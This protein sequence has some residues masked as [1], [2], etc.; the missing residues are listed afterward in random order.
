MNPIDL[1]QQIT[2][3]VS[4]LVVDLKKQSASINDSMNRIKGNDMFTAAQNIK[5]LHDMCLCCSIEK[6]VERLHKK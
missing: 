3:I 1:S 6:S 4:E 2:E 5:D